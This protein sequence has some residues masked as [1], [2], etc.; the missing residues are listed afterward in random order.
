[1]DTT[2][3]IQLELWDSN[4][5]LLLTNFKYCGAAHDS[6]LAYSCELYYSTKD[7]QIKIGTIRCWGHGDTAELETVRQDILDTLETE[8]TSRYAFIF[9]N[10]EL[11][12]SWSYV[13]DML[14][15][16]ML[17]NI[18]KITIADLKF[19]KERNGNL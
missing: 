11:R 14:V 12:F 2:Y 17:N 1:M 5:S 3:N 13:W 16:E 4:H 9:A 7:E 19:L 15:S 8:I 6:D 10:V 18:E